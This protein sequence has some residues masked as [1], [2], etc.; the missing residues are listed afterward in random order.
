MWRIS[1]T[2]PNVPEVTE[3][4]AQISGVADPF[5]TIVVTHE[6]QQYQTTADAQG[7]WS[8]LNPILGTGSVTIVA[9][10][11]EGISSQQIGLA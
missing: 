5:V 8:L 1:F 6:G 7:N 3:F 11:A 2:K 9:I 10:N 4:E